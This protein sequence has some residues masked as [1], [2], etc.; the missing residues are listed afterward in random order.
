MTDDQGKKPRILIVDDTQGNI[1]ILGTILLKEGYQVNVARNG[2]QAL[3]L[4]EKILP[5]LILLD[6][7]MPEMDGYETCRHLKSSPQTKDIPVIFLTARTDT[8]DIVKGF[9]SGA[10]DYITKPFNA[11]ELLVRVNT[12]LDLKFSKDMIETVSNERKELLHILCHDLSNTFHSIM[13]LLTLLKNYE[14]FEELKPYLLSSANNGME[15]IRLVRNMRALE[16]HKLK[17]EDIFFSEVLAQS[18]SLLKD[19]FAA[20]EIELE[21][22]AGENLKIRAERISFVNSVLNNIFTN[23]VKFSHRKSK[24]AVTAGTKGDFAEISIRDYGIGMS[25]KML[26]N[27]FDISKAASRPGTEGETGTGFGMH[28]IRKFMTAY[29]GSI[30]IL[31]KAQEENLQDHG[32]EVIL[33]LKL[34][35]SSGA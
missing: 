5:D 28:L 23:S 35:A 32:T 30:E 24:I 17:I 31:S 13:C 2:M 10:V 21:I 34:A 1:Q 29:G 18:Y 16:E 11:T 6:I 7:M 8:D 14:K 27:I 33:R 12:H 15:I 3:G 22:N 25:Q 20:K 4:V 19:R 26:R 9:E